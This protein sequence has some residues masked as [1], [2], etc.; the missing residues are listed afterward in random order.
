MFLT[1]ADPTSHRQ[2]EYMQSPVQIA[3]GNGAT[4]LLHLSP[5]G[6]NFTEST[7]PVDPAWLSHPARAVAVGSSPPPPPPRPPPPPPPSHPVLK[8]PPPAI[9]A[10]PGLFVEVFPQVWHCSMTF[11]PNR[12]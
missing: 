4:F 9:P 12:P 6:V 1:V 3:A 10:G 8:T 2:V 5:P 7:P 11:G